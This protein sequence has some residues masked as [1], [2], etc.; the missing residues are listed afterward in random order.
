MKTEAGKLVTSIQ[1]FGYFLTE[2]AM[3][4]RMAEE[5]QMERKAIAILLMKRILV[6]AAPKQEMSF[7]EKC[8]D[9]NLIKIIYM[10]TKKCTALFVEKIGVQNTQSP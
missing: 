1:Q 9:R 4:Y 2:A 8:G 7:T 5:K 3:R 10:D 6:T